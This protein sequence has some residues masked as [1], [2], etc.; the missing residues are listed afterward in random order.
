MSNVTKL[1]NILF[2][3]F[4]CLLTRSQPMV[5]R[6]R[7]SSCCRSRLRLDDFDFIGDRH[8]INGCPEKTTNANQACNN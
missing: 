2:Q 5:T 8:Q 6:L 4:E 1:K 7:N 3:I